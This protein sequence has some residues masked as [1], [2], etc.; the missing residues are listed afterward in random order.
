MFACLLSCLLACLV[1]C[2]IDWL[3]GWLVGCALLLFAW[4]ACFALLCWLARL[5]RSRVEYQKLNQTAP[6]GAV[7]LSFWCSTHSP[8]VSYFVACLLTH[9]LAYLLP[10]ACLL[11]SFVGWSVG[12]LG[13]LI[14][15][16]LLNLLG[17][18]A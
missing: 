11:A 9:L 12:L 16:G 7:W 15:L 5:N 3:V 14:L 2:L 13:M 8:A 17:L 6:Y 18:R 1:G 4:L 10:R